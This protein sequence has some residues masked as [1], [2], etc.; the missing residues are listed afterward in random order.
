MTLTKG[1]MP[2][3]QHDKIFHVPS[4]LLDVIHTHTFIWQM[5][6]LYFSK[7]LKIFKR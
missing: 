7:I 2:S 5:E 3:T 4:F 6:Y 1:P